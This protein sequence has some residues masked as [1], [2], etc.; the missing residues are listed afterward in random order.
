MYDNDDRRRECSD[1][2]VKGVYILGGCE[3]DYSEKK[4]R[5]KLFAQVC[6]CACA[7]VFCWEGFTNKSTLNK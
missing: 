6:A 7:C 2:R 3:G 4:L 1:K 5:K